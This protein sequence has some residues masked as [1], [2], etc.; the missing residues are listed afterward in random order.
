[1]MKY[2][3]QQLDRTSAQY[4]AQKAKIE[5]D[6]RT[7]RFQYIGEGST[8]LLLIAAGAIFVYRALRQQFKLSQQQRHFMMAITHE[9]KTPIAVTKLNLETLQKHRLEPEQQNRLLN[10]T[11]Q[12]A[13]RLND[14]CNNMLLSSQIEDGGYNITFEPIDFSD[15]TETVLNEYIT[16]FPKNSIEVDV[17]DNCF[18][19]GDRLLLQMVISNLVDNAIKYSPKDAKIKVSVRKH[20][21]TISL[22]VVDQGRGIED[23]EK[24]NIFKKFY[25]VGNE[26]TRSAKGTGLGLYVTQRIVKQHHGDIV[27]TNNLPSGSNFKVDLPATLEN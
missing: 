2:R 25:R 20:G 16:R 4:Q 8:F 15:L 14:L 19:T 18:V 24:R 27:V 11:I 17:E 5:K 3:E 7:R 6:L 22:N 21:K 1:M 13:N 12:E 23:K 9:L 26:H 10:N